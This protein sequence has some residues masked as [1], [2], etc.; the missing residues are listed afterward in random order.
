MDLGEFGVSDPLDGLD[1]RSGGNVCMAVIVDVFQGTRYGA[2]RYPCGGGIRFQPWLRRHRIDGDVFRDPRGVHDVRQRRR[3]ARRQ[4]RV[5]CTEA[6]Q[7][8]HRSHGGLGGLG[9]YS[10]CVFGDVQHHDHLSGCLSPQHRRHSGFV[11]R[12]R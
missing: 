11:E 8:L 7:A 4:W 3:D 9:D 2:H 5:L 12:S 10:R 1:A 6:D